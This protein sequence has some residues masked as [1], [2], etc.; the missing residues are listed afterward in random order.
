MTTAIS[1]PL[2]SAEYLR[3]TDAADVAAEAARRRTAYR[4]VRV[5]VSGSLGPAS[6][7]SHV[8]AVAVRPLLAWLGWPTPCPAAHGDQTLAYWLVAP[9]CDAVGLVVVPQ[10]D[11]DAHCRQAVVG[12]LVHGARWIVVT[13]GQV[14]RIVDA[15][16]GDGRGF[17]EF[18]LDECARDV[19]SLGW[20]ARL[21]GPP[22]FV[23][24]T[25]ASL[26]HWLATSD[27]HGR[28]VCRALRDGVGEALGT[29]TAAASGA[30]GRRRDLRACYADALTA[31][32][33]T[34][35]LLFAEA[36]HLVPM[37][38]PVYRRG[39]SIEALRTRLAE[40][41][42][43]R[44]TWAAL[45]AIA[46]LA[47]AGA[48]AGD[49][50]VTP[51]NGRLFAP[52][53]AP[54]LDHLALDDRQ[55]ASALDA[56]CFTRA[57]GATGRQR[58]AYA[59]L[60][61]EELGSVYES[62]LDLEPVATP[63]VHLQPSAGAA[64]KTTGSFYT[65][66]AM[67]DMLVR[68]T[69]GPII[70]GKTADQVLAVRVLDPAMGSGAF[71]VSAGRFL[72]AEWERAL[73]EHGDAT[74]GDISDTERAA[75][76][77]LIA[78]RCLFG[79]DRNPMAVQ[80]A[81]LSLWLATLS[82]DRP[83]SFL[84][85]HLVSGNSL[86]GASPLDVLARPPARGRAPA[87]LPLEGLF[88]WADALV[89]VRASRHDI[90]TTNDDSA[91]IVR[92][93]EAAL[94]R[95]ADD[96][97][98]T[99]WKAACD[100]WCVGWMRDAPDRRLYQALVDRSLGRSAVTSRAIDAAH[101][102]VRARAA[103]LGC[104]HWPLEFP[105][106]F[107]DEEGRP[108]QDGGFD[109]VVGN[110]PWEMLRADGRRD[111]AA[112][113]EGETLVRF[114]RDSGVYAWQGRGHANQ[115]QLFIE[116]ALQVTRPGG[117]IGLLVPASL[118]TDDGSEALRRAL[119]GANQFDTVTVFDNRHALFPIH[120]SVR[121]AMFTAGRHQ[122]TSAIRCRFG[123]TD[124]AAVDAT[125]VVTLTPRLIEQLS[126]PGL[127]IP[128]LPAPRD[129]QLV[130]SIARAHLPLA[131]PAGW[132]VGFG[133]ELNATDDRDCLREGPSMPGDLPVIDGRHL[134]PFRVDM[135]AVTR[136]ARPEA[137]SARLGSRGGAGRRRLAYRDV[138]GATNRTTL[139]AALLPAHSVS[140]HTVFCLRTRLPLDAQ[141]VLCAL[142][143]SYVANYLVR[144]RVNTH[145]TTGIIGRL[146]VPL[147]ERGS[148]LF[149]ELA[150][151]AALLERADNEP[152]VAAVQAAAADAYRLSADDLSHIL[153]TFPLVPEAD[154]AAVQE[155]F[156]RRRRQ[157][158]CR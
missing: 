33:R 51:F 108:R 109:A 55:V 87:P 139:I 60:G 96:A 75:T 106:V 65:P 142:F 150:A 126:G 148:G 35:F 128:D 9:R 22:A 49:L 80:L 69:L 31:V 18:D 16:R 132:H 81:Q 14:L 127:A 98:L 63:T 17:I 153:A 72:A 73:V 2:L 61:V 147:V 90:E 79:V 11:A 71:L 70:A 136:H 107:L 133:R 56:L 59:D 1:G 54:L 158:S 67:A 83:L 24:G 57:G 68:D 143:N 99:R 82:S 8:H 40:S 13:D 32:Y 94:A 111:A 130:E 10:G 6:H 86:I 88:E 122:R 47:H 112:A 15:L 93:K 140:V 66:R 145:V 95:V 156:V 129:L 100:L 4:A 64:R 3:Q 146:P 19:T 27:A 124:P 105:E 137:V 138:A 20:L 76:R 104:F 62:L 34:L 113:T 101:Q 117:R 44:G 121:F 52:A 30:P 28:R 25:A 21:A 141:R 103:A 41:R 134:S 120:R 92:G 125:P 50:K 118:L 37:W 23:P 77:R 97:G 7:P 152:A 89:T 45:Q 85:H 149:D 38:H 157:Q 119:I 39:Y 116:R 29:F 151:G 154:R 91:D 48:H 115:F 74:A 110:P 131:D 42:S 78:S 5:P 26:S 144:R 102:H 123:V 135:Q 43:P 58:I 53:R 36:R 84:D 12:A 155:A 46:R 114:A